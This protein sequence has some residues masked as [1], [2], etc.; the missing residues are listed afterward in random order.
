MYGL[1]A[2][3]WREMADPTEA[4]EVGW[5][6]LYVLDYKLLFFHSLSWGCDLYSGEICKYIITEFN[7][8]I[9]FTMP[10]TRGRSRHAYLRNKFL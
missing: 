10:T 8:F 7:I 9:I 4:L 6:I 2:E 3:T 1:N 5:R